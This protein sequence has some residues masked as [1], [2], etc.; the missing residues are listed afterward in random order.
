[1]AEISPINELKEI[2][3]WLI[4]NW[5]YMRS[6][7]IM[8]S[9]NRYDRRSITLSITLEQNDTT[10]TKRFYGV[11]LKDVHKQLHDFMSQPIALIPV[12]QKE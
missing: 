5:N 12:M 8:K 6:Y 11:D 4:L 9:N 1:M 2:N 3:E 10:F 7:H